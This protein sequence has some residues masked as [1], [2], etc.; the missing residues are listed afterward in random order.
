MR[1]KN[2]LDGDLIHQRLHFRRRQPATLERGDRIANRFLPRLGERRLLALLQ[3]TNPLTVLSEVG[4]FQE[5]AETADND[6]ELLFAEFRQQRF[7][8][9]ARLIVPLAHRTGQAANLLDQIEARVAGKLRDRRAERPAQVVDLA[10]QFVM[11]IAV[12][13]HGSFRG[14]EGRWGRIVRQSSRSTGFPR[15]FARGGRQAPDARH[16]TLGESCR[17]TRET[18]D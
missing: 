14:R 4:E 2:E 18:A 6:L 15:A 17:D 3:R 13:S 11:G 7:E 16:E 5:N 9:L 12:G 1:G 10:A 8:R